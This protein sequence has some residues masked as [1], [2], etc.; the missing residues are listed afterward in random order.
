[1]TLFYAI[2]ATAC[3]ILVCTLI[4]AIDV[5]RHKYIEWRDLRDRR[6]RRERMQRYGMMSRERKL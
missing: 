5:A 1:M 3:T 6:I 2:L 4:L